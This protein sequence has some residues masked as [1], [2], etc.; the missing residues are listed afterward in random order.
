MTFLKPIAQAALLLL[1]A[2]M[3]APGCVIAEPRDGYYDHEHH[4]YYHEHGWREC[5]EEDEHCR[6]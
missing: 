5:R 2:V 4:R 1:G 3:F 6:R